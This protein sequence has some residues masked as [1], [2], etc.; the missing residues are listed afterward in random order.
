VFDQ[1][2]FPSGWTATAKAMALLH[3]NK[4]FA[5]IMHC[6]RVVGNQ[7]ESRNFDICDLPF[8]E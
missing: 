5:E 4:H 1:I 3:Q 8:V 7:R 2:T 6:R